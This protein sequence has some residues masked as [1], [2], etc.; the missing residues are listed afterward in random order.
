MITKDVDD[1]RGLTLY[2]DTIFIIA[3]LDMEYY[4][5][6]LSTFFYIFIQKK[7]RIL[8]DS[9]TL[10]KIPSLKGCDALEI[11]RIDRCR[12]SELPEDL[13]KTSPKLKS[14]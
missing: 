10:E 4:P 1:E 9:R 6:Y 2:D 7:N 5:F 14:L 12:L 13:C 3:Y 8:S 11:I